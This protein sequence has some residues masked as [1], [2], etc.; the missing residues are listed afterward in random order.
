MAGSKMAL[1]N[2]QPFE[3]I[4]Q[5]YKVNEPAEDVL[6]HLIHVDFTTQ[7]DTCDLLVGSQ[8]GIKVQAQ[9]GYRYMYD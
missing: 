3:Q 1:A 8:E 9:D 2:N 7:V 5:G 4:K 6:T